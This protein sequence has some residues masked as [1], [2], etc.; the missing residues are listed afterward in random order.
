[1]AATIKVLGQVAPSA[2]V[3]TAL[4]TCGATSAVVSSLFI[5]N[6]DP[7][8]A[9]TFTIRISVANAAD[10]IKQVLFYNSPIPAATMLN[11]VAGITLANTDVIKVVSTNGTCSF[12][13]F[14]QENS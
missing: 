12:S 11:I 7:S 4:Y 2:T 14:G 6:T 10:N 1:M 9:D 3:Q 5:C 8:N 13:A